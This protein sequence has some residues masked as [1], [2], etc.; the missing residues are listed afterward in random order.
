MNHEL[1]KQVMQRERIGG[2][3]RVNEDRGDER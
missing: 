3:R 2:K 1:D